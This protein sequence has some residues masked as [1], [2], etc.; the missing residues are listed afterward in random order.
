MRKKEKE[1][2]EVRFIASLIEHVAIPGS[3]STE[4]EKPQGVSALPPPT[5]F[6]C[7]ALVGR[8]DMDEGGDL[9]LPW[10]RVVDQIAFFTGIQ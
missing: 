2:L 6:L 9:G 4:S 8:G 10:K 5:V 3:G 1:S 7:R